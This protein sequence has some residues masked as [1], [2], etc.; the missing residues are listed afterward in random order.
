LTEKSGIVRNMIA[1]PLF[2]HKEDYEKDKDPQV[3]IAVL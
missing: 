2:G 3:P 1:A